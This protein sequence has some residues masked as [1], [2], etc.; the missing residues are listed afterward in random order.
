MHPTE[1]AGGL[2]ERAGLRRV[3][4]L[5]LVVLYGVGVT[6]GA[7][8]YVLIGVTVSAAGLYAPL[9]FLLA[10]TV[11]A[12]SAASFAELSCRYPLSA[13]EAAYVQAGFGSKRLA[14]IIGLMVI[15]SATVS[16]SA[17]SIGAAGYVSE[18]VPLPDK[19]LVAAIV[20]LMA[21]VAAWGIMESVSFAALFTIVEVGGLLAIIVAGLYADPLLVMRMSEIVPPFTEAA[22]WFAVYGAGLLAFF[23]FV[24]FE[25]IVNLAEEVKEPRRT[26]P[27]A[28]FLTL[29]ISTVIY[30]LVVSVAVL[31][32]PLPALAESK[33][34]LSYVFTEITGLSPAAISAIAI[35]ATLNGVIVQIVMASRVLYGLANQGNAPQLLARIN[36]LT[37]TPLLATGLVGALIL[38]LALF[39]PLRDLAEVTSLIVL[40]IFVFVNASLVLLKWRKTPPPDGAFKV[41]LLVPVLGC[42]SCLF[43]LAGGLFSP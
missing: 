29:V 26:L 28:I 22:P 38:S 20:L 33:A 24:G 9:S 4:S 7:G 42:A 21:G 5:P 18:F 34:P 31:S 39:F 12:L 1:A 43:V 3:L 41:P 13:G 23:A 27:W 10:A 14:L 6:V 35:V 30:I 16:S 25:D 8:I 2:P 17:I 11:V 37:R 36:P 19:V 40:A 15:A 32:V